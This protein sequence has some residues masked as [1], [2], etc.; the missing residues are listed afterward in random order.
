MS[1]PKLILV[2]TDDDPTFSEVDAAVGD[3]EHSLVHI[4][5]GRELRPAVAEHEPD[6]VVCDLQVGS[7]GG[8]AATI[9]LHLE[10]GAGRLEPVPVLLL[11]DREADRFIAERSGADRWMAKPLEAG[12]L[13]R[14]ALEL[15]EA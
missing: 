5:S 10:A 11:V 15:L 3:D 14:N 12:E 7:M 4:R 2:V 6:L 9:D 1:E 8:V 13:R